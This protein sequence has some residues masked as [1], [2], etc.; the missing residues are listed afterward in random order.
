[1]L[2]KIFTMDLLI[3]IASHV[4]FLYS[5]IFFIYKLATGQQNAVNMEFFEVSI[6]LFLFFN[7]GK[8]IEEKLQKSSNQDLKDLFKLKNKNSFILDNG[9]KIQ[10]PTHKIT[11]GHCVLV[12]KGDSVPVDGQLLS[13]F[14]ILNYQSINGEPLPL[15]FHKN[16]EIL[17]GS[18]NIGDTFKL[19]ATKKASESFL[20]Q[21]I[22]RLENIFES[23]SKIETISKK[24]VSIFTPAVLILSIFAFIIWLTVGYLLG[25]F[26]KIYPGFSLPRD[27][28]PLS[29]AIYIA[30][31]VLVISCPCAFG[32]A[33]PIAIYSSSILASKN[34]IL[35]ANSQ[36]YEQILLSKVIIFDKTGTLT[37]GMPK[38]VDFQ[39]DPSLLLL[40]KQMT[41]NSTHPI[42]NAIFNFID[43]EVEFLFAEEIPGQGLKYVDQQGTIW[44]IL[45]HDFA[46]KNNF[47]QNQNF[48]FTENGNYTVL[49]KNYEIVAVFLIKDEIK[50]TAKDTIK[51]LQNQGFK[52]IIASGDNQKNVADIAKKVGI[53]QFFA[54]LQPQAKASLVA[55]LQKKSPVIFVGDGINDVLATKTAALSMAFETGS[56]LNNSI[57]DVSLLKPDLILVYK[58]IEIVR[59][60]NKLIKINFTWAI[61]FNF[62]FV[63]LAFLGFI[64][65][66]IAML[67]MLFSSIFLIINT[68]F[69]KKRNQ[70]FLSKSQEQ[71]F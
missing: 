58:A 62:L 37:L 22:N 29:A 42:S 9:K 33:A 69:F 41:Q 20:M 44:Q 3:A 59:R 10:I 30:V 23:P 45:S 26:Q 64:Y 38:V 17:S 8:F 39:G 35:F 12:S 32:I 68:L 63:P 21:T 13:D 2:K 25:D 55:D 11:K 18:V 16:Q 40:A 43:H 36:V 65:P 6:V 48:S 57:A 53:S 54:N 51:K 15:E 14:A 31:A 61:L 5:A 19:L 52:C 46:I 50:K 49:A 47:L 1:M 24:I 4:S 70:K 71:D 7:V 27:S 34:K 66:I 56:G 67:L 28:S 60:T